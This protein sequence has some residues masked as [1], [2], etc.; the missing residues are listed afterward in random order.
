[1]SG[2][3]LLGV[4]VF[5]LLAGGLG[6]LAFV[7]A[8]FGGAQAMHGRS[9]PL[10][11]GE[12]LKAWAVSRSRG[13][14]AKWLAS[15]PERCGSDELARQTEADAGKVLDEVMFRESP[16]AQ[17]VQRCGEGATAPQVTAPEVFA[18]VGELR[19]LP[20]RRQEELKLQVSSAP[21]KSGI[22]PLLTAQRMCLCAAARPLGCRG[23]C[24]AGFDSSVDAA[25][26]AETLEEGLIEGLQQ[27]L[28]GAG[29]DGERYDL[30][31][32]LATVLR[33]PTAESRWQSGRP[34]MAAGT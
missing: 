5:V 13:T 32:A 33:D 8:A 2:I 31:A 10:L 3:L 22:C 15:R 6:V 9:L 7:D 12:S 29:L 21:T 17:G 16:A 4:S 28:E 24:L 18:I 27:T 23:R 30:T 19:K 1:M 26:W 14:A 34:L 11:T 25:R 20:M